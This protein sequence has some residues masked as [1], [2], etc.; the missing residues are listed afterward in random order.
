MFYNFVRIHQTLRITP[1]MAV[2]VTDRVWDIADIVRM[3]EEREA[4]ELRE[5]RD[6]RNERSY[7]PFRPALGHSEHCDIAMENMSQHC[8]NIGTSLSVNQP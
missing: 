3:V 5:S 2:G 7:N 4:R 1:A 6:E 8:Q